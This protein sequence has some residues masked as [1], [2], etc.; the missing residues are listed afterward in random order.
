MNPE[1]PHLVLEGTSKG[2]RGLVRTLRM[3]RRRAGRE[4]GGSSK[5]ATWSGETSKGP[6]RY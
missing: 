3:S 2:H 5:P 4:G 6:R 1:Q